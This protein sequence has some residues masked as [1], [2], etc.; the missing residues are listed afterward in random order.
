MWV[1]FSFAWL[2]ILC[3]KKKTVFDKFIEENRQSLGHLLDDAP[4]LLES[5]SESG[6]ESESELG[7]ESESGSD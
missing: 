1:K 6:L 4:S 3:C 2:N 7:L 5:G